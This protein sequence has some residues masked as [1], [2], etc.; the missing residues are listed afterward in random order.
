[1]DAS[2]LQIETHGSPKHIVGLGWGCRKEIRYEDCVEFSETEK[3][4]FGM[5]KINLKFKLTDWDKE[6]IEKTKL[7]QSKAAAAFGKV[8]KEGEQTL[9]PPGTS[10]HA[11]GTVRMG[12]TNNGESVCDSYSN[13]WG[14]DNL[15]V[16]GNGVIPMCTTSNPTLTSVAMAVRASSKIIEKL[17][18][19]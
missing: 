4:F 2:P 15:F 11:A 3:G 5:P 12:E 6:Q 1:M 13:V 17:T 7:I 16:G 14:Y 9:I 18:T 8:F 10:L 19:T